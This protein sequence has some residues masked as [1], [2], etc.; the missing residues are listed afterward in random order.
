M[1]IQPQNYKF[2]FVT[3]GMG[4]HATP[5]S[6]VAENG[7]CSIVPQGGP[8]RVYPM[9]PQYLLKYV[10]GGRVVSEVFGSLVK[11]ALAAERLRLP[12]GDK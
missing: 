8:C 5:T 7:V 9:K 12:G 2:R 11:A 1:S 10:Q 4:W 6:W 3:G